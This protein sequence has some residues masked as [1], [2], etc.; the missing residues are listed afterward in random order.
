MNNVQLSWPLNR[1]LGFALVLPCIITIVVCLAFGGELYDIPIIV[2]NEDGGHLGTALT[3]RLFN[4]SVLSAVFL[5]YTN[6][7]KQTQNQSVSH[8]FIDDFGC[9]GAW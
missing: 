3:S 2:V 8:I 7:T 1:L 6:S 5:I 9:L 4:S